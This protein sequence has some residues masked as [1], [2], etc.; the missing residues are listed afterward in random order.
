VDQPRRVRRGQAAPG[1]DEHRDHLAPC[2]PC[3]CQPLCQ[4]LAV[5]QLHRQEHAVAEHPDVVDLHHVGV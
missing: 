5:D 4:R 1:R 2:P 3:A